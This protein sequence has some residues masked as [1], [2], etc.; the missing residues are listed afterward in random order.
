VGTRDPQ[1]STSDRRKKTRSENAEKKES[2]PLKR[3]WRK[4]KGKR[5]P[6]KEKK[7]LSPESEKKGKNRVM[8]VT[9]K[10]EGRTK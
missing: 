4:K 5:P 10:K 3:S 6:T 9:W 7:V 1:R 2:E 8:K